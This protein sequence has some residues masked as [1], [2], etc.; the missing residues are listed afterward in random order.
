M[1]RGP[2]RVM[3]GLRSLEVS[4]RGRP[5]EICRTGSG[6]VRGAV[7]DDEKGPGVGHG[8][9]TMRGSHGPLG[10]TGIR[11]SGLYGLELGQWAMSSDLTYNIGKSTRALAVPR[12]WALEP[13]TV[14][15]D[16]TARRLAVISHE[17]LRFATGI[18]LIPH[19][20]GLTSTYT[21]RNR[22]DGIQKL[23]QAGD[24]DSK[25]ALAELQGE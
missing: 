16:D 6:K 17:S 12:F 23:N 25:K 10:N 19:C 3:G 5:C 15:D 22:A 20:R 14:T 18:W 7:F 9:A 8:W 4:V 2:G 11:G 13:D 21:H 1:R 24:E